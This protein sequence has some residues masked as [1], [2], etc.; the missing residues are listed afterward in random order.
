MNRKIEVYNNCK[1]K[2]EN[3]CIKAKKRK[4]MPK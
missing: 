4:K 3:K 1:C 2:A